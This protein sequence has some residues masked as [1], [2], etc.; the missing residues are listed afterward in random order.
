MQWMKLTEAI[1]FNTI[2]LLFLLFAAI[3]FNFPSEYPVT[4]ESM[5]YT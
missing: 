4:H 2:G 3:T 5:N 1:A